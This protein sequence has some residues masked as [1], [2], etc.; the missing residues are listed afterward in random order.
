MLSEPS[1]TIT[2]KHTKLD[3]GQEHTFVLTFPLSRVPEA[4]KE[5]GEMAQNPD[6]PFTWYDAAVV[7]NEIR[8]QK[9]MAHLAADLSK[10][11]FTRE[12]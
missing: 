10:F 11:N 1:P 5:V 7:A 8:K 2:V 3:E 4:F 12:P 6:L 9:N